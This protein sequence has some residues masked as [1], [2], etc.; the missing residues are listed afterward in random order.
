M[1]RNA[2]RLA[3]FGLALAALVAAPEAGVAQVYTPDQLSEMPQ[4]DS[5]RDAM[6]AIQESY[7]RRLRDRGIEGRVQVSFVVNSDGRVDPESVEVVQSENSELKDAAMQ[8]VRQIRFRPGRKDGSA[9]AARVVIP[10]AYT[11]S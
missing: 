9:V 5:P 11:V 2:H 7:P 1:V 4:I 3:A 6:Q 10:I 8:A